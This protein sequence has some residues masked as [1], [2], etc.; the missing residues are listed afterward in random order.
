MMD[1]IDKTFLPNEFNTISD[2]NITADLTEN[3]S[4]SILNSSDPPMKV[5]YASP[6]FLIPLHTLT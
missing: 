1:K 4:S 2:H 5:R 3:F 6:H